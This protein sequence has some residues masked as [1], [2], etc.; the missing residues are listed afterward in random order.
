MPNYYIIMLNIIMSHIPKNQMEQ[1]L[2]KKTKHFAS[3]NM[4]NF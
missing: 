3:I 1:I 4:L 2:K